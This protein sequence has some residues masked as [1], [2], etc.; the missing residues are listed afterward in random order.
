MSKE[1]IGLIEKSLISKKIVEYEIYFIDTEIYET[2]FIKSVIASERE[3]NKLE[4]VIRILSQ[5]GNETGIGIVKGNSLEPKDID[6]NIEKCIQL[7]FKSCWAK[8]MNIHFGCIKIRKLLSI[9]YVIG[10][11]IK[12]TISLNKYTK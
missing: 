11:L 12:H 1:K 6:K 2:E 9:P 5:K 7:C 3:V 8:P 10:D 4:Y